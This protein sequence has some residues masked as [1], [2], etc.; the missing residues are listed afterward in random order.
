[1]SKNIEI[2]KPVVGYEGLYEVSSYGRVRSL[3]RATSYISRTQ[4]GKEY[5][6]THTLKGKLMKQ[7]VNQNGYKEIALC[8][9]GKSKKYM[10]HR[11]VAEAFLDNPNNYPII[12]HK[13]ENKQNN[14]IWINKNGLIDYK[15]SNLEWCTQK[16][17]IN[18]GSGNIRRINTRNKNKSYHYQ[19]KVGQYTLK[20]VLIKK[21]PSASDTGYCRECIR[22][23]CNGKQKTA[24]GYKWRYLN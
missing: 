2:W 8:V 17:N 1:M 20:G 9:G 3:D 12:N 16:Y 23:C 21:Y 5:T 14:I 10:V 22:D 6:T 4:E 7:R 11:L 13:D 15:K 19:R 18:Y 24:Y